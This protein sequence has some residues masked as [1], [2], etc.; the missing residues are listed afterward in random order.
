MAAGH[1]NERTDVTVLVSFPVAEIKMKIPSLE[2]KCLH[3][4][5]GAE[6]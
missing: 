3:G 6:A 4:K 1:S 5:L 2:K